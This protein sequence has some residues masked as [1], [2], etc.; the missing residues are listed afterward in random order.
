MRAHWAYFKY[1]MRHKWFV[2]LAGRKIGVGWWQLLVH[3]FSKFSFAE[4]GAYVRSFYNPDGTKRDWKSRTARETAEFDW[5]WNHHQKTN[6]HH[7]QYWVLTTDSDEPRYRVLPMPYKFV[8]EM[9]ADWVGAGRAITGRI[10]VHEWYKANR[11]KMMFDLQV[12]VQVR[13]LLSKF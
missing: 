11:H 6:P 3:D 1:V 10:E 2:L 4:W 7:W 9:V 5:A 8:K 13:H 12:E